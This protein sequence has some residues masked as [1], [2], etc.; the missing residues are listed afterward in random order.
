MDNLETKLLKES[1]VTANQFIK[2]KEDQKK[3]K[4]S[5]Y[6]T[7]IRLGYLTEKDIYLFFAQHVHIP[8]VRLTDYKSNE[9]LIKL[10]SEELYREHLFV[11]LF[12]IDDILYVAM[13]NPLDTELISLLG[14][15]TKFDIFPLFSSPSSILEVINQFFGPDDKY[16]NLEDLIIAPQ[17]L[18]MVPFLRESER[19]KVEVPIEF[20]IDDNRINLISEGYVSGT[21]TDISRSGKALGIRT[22]IFVP[23]RIKIILK[24]PSYDPS[25]LVQSEIAHCDIVE[26]GQYLLGV[27][28]K[29]VKE[30]L[31]KSILNPKNADDK[32]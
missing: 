7:L 31:V 15:Q 16:F 5:I 23:P 29:A 14:I 30:D 11:P 13:A 8:F 24:F 27:E 17:T 32:V 25:Y 19:V 1:W 12:T 6:S 18:H 22:L 21:C 2:A 20:K 9:Q 3:I 26:N 28:L 4:K 10:F